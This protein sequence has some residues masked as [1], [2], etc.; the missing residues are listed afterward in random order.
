MLLLTNKYMFKVNNI[1]P[2][3]SV[4]Y[5]YLVKLTIE[6]PEQSLF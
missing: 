4:Q 2:K 5:G 6:T 1:K 3:K